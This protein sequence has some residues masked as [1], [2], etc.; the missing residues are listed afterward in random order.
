MIKRVTFACLILAAMA[1]A[2]A[3]GAQP[4]P[5][6]LPDTLRAPSGHVLLFETFATGVQIYTCTTQAD[7]PAKF[8]WTFKAPEAEL[9]TGRGEKLGTHDAGPTWRGNDGSTVVAEVAA[10]AD[11]PDAGAI[12]WLLLTAKANDGAGAFGAVTYIQR[13]ETVGGGA[14]ADGCDPSA[15]GVERAV[16]YTAVYAFFYPAAP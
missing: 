6:A 14:P 7:D 10:R 2:P 5:T 9:W 1:A 11:A 13:L 12:P 15:A 3:V 4:G 16:P 8:A